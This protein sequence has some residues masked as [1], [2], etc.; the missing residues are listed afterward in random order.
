MAFAELGDPAG[1][2]AVARNSL[3]EY[4]DV[5]RAIHGLDRVLPAVD[6]F[7]RK[8][9]VAEGVPV[10]GGFPQRAADDFRRIDF[11]VTANDELLAHVADEILE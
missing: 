5:A 10:S 6:S 7:G 4:L 11:L 3:L 1:Q 8:H 2:V 9:V